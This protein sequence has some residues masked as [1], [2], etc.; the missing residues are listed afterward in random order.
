MPKAILSAWVRPETKETFEVEVIQCHANYVEYD[1]PALDILGEFNPANIFCLFDS[2]ATGLWRLVVSVT[3]T[4][5]TIQAVDFTEHDIEYDV[6]VLVMEKPPGWAHLRR[7]WARIKDEMCTEDENP[8]SSAA[9]EMNLKL[10]WVYSVSLTYTKQEGAN[11]SLYSAAV[12]FTTPAG[13]TLDLP[14]CKA[15]AHNLVLR[16]EKGLYLD[17]SNY[18]LATYSVKCRQYTVLDEDV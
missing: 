10:V 12:Q 9:V 15:N 11:L 6:E 2:N 4:P 5:V 17:V 1:D 7:V 16:N 3:W 13:V 8:H 18:T 14:A